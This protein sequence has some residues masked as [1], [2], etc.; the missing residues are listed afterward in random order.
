MYKKIAEVCKSGN[1]IK[2]QLVKNQV[3]EC[4]ITHK[5]YKGMKARENYIMLLQFGKVVFSVSKQC[6]LEII[7]G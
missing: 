3:G 2:L 4:Q 5:A 6:V 7:V 1:V